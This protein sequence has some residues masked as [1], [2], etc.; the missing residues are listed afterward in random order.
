MPNQRIGSVENVAVGAVVLLKLDHPLDM[1][2]ALQVLH[3]GRGGT[4]PAVDRLIIVTDRKYR[5]V[6]PCQQLQPAILQAV[7][8]LEFVDQDVAKAS[9]IVVT[10]RVVARQQLVGPQQQLG[11]VDDALALAAAVVF[12]INLDHAPRNVIVR[13][14][15][16]GALALFFLGGDEPLHL[17]RRIT[18]FV[19]VHALHQ[20]LHQRQLVLGVEDLEQLR[21]TGLAV[22]RAQHAV[23]QSVEGSHPHAAGVDRQHRRQPGQHFL[24]RLVG[25]GHREHAHRADLPG[26]DQP[27]HARGQHARLAA[28]RAGQDQRGL[29]RQRDSFELMFVK[30]GEKGWGHCMRCDVRRDYT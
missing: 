15:L 22:M 2:I 30:T 18:L 13:L 5:V 16:V 19:D 24:R 25:E 14:D 20:P 3:V 9:G 23:A 6:F 7:G 4:A 1:E 27:G 10:Q 29:M 28:A 11:E 26:L 17:A 21:Q 8:V 12:C